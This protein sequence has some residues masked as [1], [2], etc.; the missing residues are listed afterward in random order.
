MYFG[1]YIIL[2]DAVT[3]DFVIA[4]RKTFLIVQIRVPNLAT[5]IDRIAKWTLIN[6]GE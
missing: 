5:A 2:K 1:D 4:H 3:G 6:E